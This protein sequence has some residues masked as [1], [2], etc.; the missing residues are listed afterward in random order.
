M[1]AEVDSLYNPDAA[2]QSR[3]EI[4]E[5]MYPYIEEQLQQGCYLGHITRHLL[6]LF[7]AQAGGR[8][9]RRYLSEN[10]HKAGAGVDVLKQA[11]ARVAAI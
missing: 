11:V 8:Q 7:H 5:Q 2:I 1:M 10:A 3:L 6:G 4:I 9:F